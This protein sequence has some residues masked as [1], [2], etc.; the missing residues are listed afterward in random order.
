MVTVPSGLAEYYHTDHHG[1][2][3]A[4][5]RGDN[6][7]IRQGPVLYDAYGNCFVGA[8]A[9]TTLGAT[10]N[11]FLYTG[12]YLDQETGLFYDR[13]RSYSSTLGR[14]AQTDPVGYD[15]DLNLYLYGENDPVNE[16][17]P[18]G[19]NTY[20][21]SRPVIPDD[22]AFKIATAA[23]LLSERMVPGSGA[24]CGGCDLSA[25][26]VF[27]A[28][29]FGCHKRQFRHSAFLCQRNQGVGLGPVQ[30]RDQYRKSF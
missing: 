4:T 14:F 5:S 13:A 25:G 21:V 2:V 22:V 15:A 24:V 8:A 10:A 12:M 9:C 11:P 29:V 1:S 17:D 16:T 20:M 26:E 28:F 19:R 27:H 23:G 18:S 7:N 3:V 30:F 6:G